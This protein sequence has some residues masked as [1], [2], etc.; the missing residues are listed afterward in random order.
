MS[1]NI[2]T[3]IPPLGNATTAGVRNNFSAAKTEIEALQQQIGFADYNDAATGVTPISVSPGTWTKLTNDKLGPFT[4]NDSLPFGITTVWNSTTNQFELSE[5]PVK[6]MVEFRADI[7]VTTTGPSKMVKSRLAMGIGSA[8][9]FYLPTTESTFK[10]AAAH[11]MV[12]NIPFYIGSND[13]KNYPAEYQIYSDGACTVRVNGWY[14]R[15]IKYLW[16]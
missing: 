14:I 5:L 13:I 6:T 11:Q 7:E 9:Q 2:D 16:G 12:S 4:V 15:I 10:S 8:S 1:S 3:S